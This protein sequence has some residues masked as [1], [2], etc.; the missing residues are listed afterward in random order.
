MN[1]LV[2]PGNAV[3]LKFIAWLIFSVSLYRLVFPGNAV[4]LKFIAWLIFSVSLSASVWGQ[5]GGAHVGFEEDQAA[6]KAAQIR[7]EKL[8][9]QQAAKE[10]RL[11]ELAGE[12]ARRQEAIVELQSQ[13][14]IYDQSLIEAY[15]DVARLYLEL[16]DYESAAGALGEALQIVRIN[17]GLYSEQ[18]LPLIQALIDAR[19]RTQQWQEVDD[20]AHLTH[21]ISQR[22]YEW[23][24][25]VIRENLLQQNSRGLMNTTE[26]LSSFYEFVISGL[27]REAGADARGMMALLQGKSQ[28][29]IVMARNIASTPY[30]YF[31]GTESQYITQSRCQN[32]R[33]AAGQVVRQCVNVQVENPR[34]RQ[35]QQ[36]AKRMALYRHTSA[37][38]RSLERMRKLYSSDSRL[39]VSEK[40]EFDAV[41]RQLQTEADALRRVRPSGFLF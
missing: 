17:S 22:L 27:E 4:A 6:A 11:Q 34:Y 30:N 10:A 31:Q 26:D 21:H 16:E 37:I 12:L 2:F 36:E 5:S 28:A 25:R 18:Q 32:R 19:S 8:A 33:N 1:R 29:D 39:S 13:Q 3:A 38:D 40:Q 41:V 7:A 24:L 20:L 35:S 14:G 23:K 15:D 9:R